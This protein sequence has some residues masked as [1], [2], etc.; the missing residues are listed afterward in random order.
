MGARGPA[1]ASTP[2]L[3][4]EDEPHGRSA[5]GL[6]TIQRLHERRPWQVILDLGIGGV[7]W[8]PHSVRMSARMGA[9]KVH[10]VLQK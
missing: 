10:A 9:L 4:V 5:E 3:I 2:L 8:R 6:A 7:I 1:R